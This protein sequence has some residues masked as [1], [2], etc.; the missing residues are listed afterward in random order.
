MTLDWQIE[1]EPPAPRG[2]VASGR[3]AD[4]LLAVLRQRLEPPAPLQLCAAPELLVVLGNSA[5]LPWVDGGVYVAPRPHAPGLWLPTTERPRWPLD[6]VERA[7][8]RRHP[9]PLLLLRDPAVL[10]PLGS[11]QSW[12]A[13]VYARLAAHWA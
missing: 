7:A 6:L 13:D 10:L 1:A 9:G 11:A 5:E 4:A 3:V 8:L 12:S 2:L